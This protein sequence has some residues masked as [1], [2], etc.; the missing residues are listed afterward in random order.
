MPRLLHARFVITGTSSLVAATTTATLG[1]DASTDGSPSE[2]ADT[3]IADAAEAGA[4]SRPASNAAALS[5]TAG[6]ASVT[7]EATSS[8]ATAIVPKKV[9]C[10]WKTPSGD[11][12]PT[13]KTILIKLQ[14]ILYDMTK[15]DGLKIGSHKFRWFFGGFGPAY[16]V[17]E[18]SKRRGEVPSQIT[19]TNLEDAGTGI[20]WEVLTG[21]VTGRPQYDPKFPNADMTLVYSVTRTK[22]QR[23][24][25]QQAANNRAAAEAK[26]AAEREAFL[27]TLKQAAPEPGCLLK[28]AQP[29]R[30]MEIRICDPDQDIKMEDLY[31]TK[32]FEGISLDYYAT[33]V[34]GD[35]QSCTRIIL[36]FV[37]SPLYEVMDLRAGMQPTLC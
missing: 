20:F 14:R 26:A 31:D 36:R 13:V 29:V 17:L 28:E 23:A 34:N 11:V 25:E 15:D 22:K 9:A 8:A 4:E 10:R 27:D 7:A 6:V 1:E 33:R 30:R 35:R 32:D 19:L 18:E 21:Q 3:R 37:Q 5:T 16:D 2:A 24:A 12:L